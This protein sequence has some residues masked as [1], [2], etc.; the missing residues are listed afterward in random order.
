M[1][2]IAGFTAPGRDAELVIAA[3]N[4]ALTHR[5]PDGSGCFVDDRIALG[6]TRLAIIDLAGGAQPRVDAA[7]GDALT[8]NGEIYGYRA[9]AAELRGAGIALCDRSDTEVLFQLIRRDGVRRAVSRIDGMF[10]FAFRDGASGALYLVRDRFG[11]KPL[12]YGV[13]NG[14]LV[15]GSEAAALFCHPAFR[16]AEPDPVAA[17]RHLL[18]EYL[19]RTGSG[20]I[21]IEKLEPGTILTCAKG[22]IS[23]EHYWLPRLDPDQI[24]P[25]EAADQ[26]EELLRQSVR[27]CVVADVPVGVF[28]SGGIDSSLIAAYAAEAAPDL[29]AFTVRVGGEGF[30]ETP[31]AVAVA[32]RLGLRHEIVELGN[33][34]LIDAFDAVSDRLSEP[35]GDSSLLPSYLVCRAARQM[36]TVALGG[37]GAD[38]LFAGYPNFPVQGFAPAMRLIPSQFGDVLGRAIGALPGAEG[39]MSWR[40]QF[41]QLTQGFGAPAARQSFLWMAPFAP[42]HLSALWRCSALPVDALGRAF[43]PIDRCAANAAGLGPVDQLLYLFLVTYLP[44][45]ILT[46]TDRA[47]M[48]N[49]L[50]VR[51]PFLDRRFAEYACALPTGLKLNGRSRKYILKQ[52]ARR[53]LP[54]AIVRRKKHGFAVPIG[55]LIRTL[56]GERCRDVLLSRRNRIADWF[57]RAAIEALLDEH[58]SGRRDHGKKLWALY[59]LFSVMGRRRVPDVAVAV[60]ASAALP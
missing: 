60:P 51:A 2:G 50:E 39:Y 31:H 3:M 17:Y 22:R 46:K 44:D 32:S 14:Q 15:F 28:L 8:F 20:W 45:D 43:A 7:T 34:D 59:T 48:F 40:F 18:F 49:G 10:A 30:D 6:H 25:N 12:Y 37:D 9:L 5:G 52:I 47:S 1:C 26:L 11:E 33:G 4:R 16:D 38:E 36:M 57:E 55:T 58:M 41:R 35:L 53:H 19:P 54:E 21:G 27:R 56:F 13:A 42:A 23:L 24:D 29:T